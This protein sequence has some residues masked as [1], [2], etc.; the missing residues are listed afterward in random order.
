STRTAIRRCNQTI[1]NRE[2]RPYRQ[3]KSDGTSCIE[4]AYGSASDARRKAGT[5]KKTAGCQLET[6]GNGRHRR[7]TSGRIAA[8]SS[9]KP[10]TRNKTPTGRPEQVSSRAGGGAAARRF[11]VGPGRQKRTRDA[12]A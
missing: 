2:A 9:R 3:G 7:K 5:R 12:T 11:G 1:R 4:I 6:L 10:G 8:C